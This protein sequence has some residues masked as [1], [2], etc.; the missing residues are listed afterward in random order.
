MWEHAQGHFRGEG[1]GRCLKRHARGQ[2]SSLTLAATN[3]QWF[4]HKTNF[5]FYIMTKAEKK[6]LPTYDKQVENSY[7]LCR[8]FENQGTKGR[9]VV[10]T[11][12]P[13]LPHIDVANIS[14]LRMHLDGRGG[15]NVLH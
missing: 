11:K 15:T 6:D 5:A 2:R 14:P 13:W 7:K 8:I 4:V 12:V 3:N 9:E 10:R 1:Y